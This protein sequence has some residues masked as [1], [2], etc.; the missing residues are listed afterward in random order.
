M[1]ETRHAYFRIVNGVLITTFKEH[2]T[3]DLK[4]AHEIVEDRKKITEGKPYPGIGY[5]KG[6]RALTKDARNYFSSDEAT[7]GVLAGAL[8]IESNF[9]AGLINFFLK[10]NP[11]KIPNRV[12]TTEEKAIEWLQQFKKE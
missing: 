11:P 12:F 5:V 3:I 7:E 8:V 6:I 1:I 10:I 9:A 4:L 2:I